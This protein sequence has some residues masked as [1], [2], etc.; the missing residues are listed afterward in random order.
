MGGVGGIGR[1]TCMVELALKAGIGELAVGL[2]RDLL[3][4]GQI[5]PFNEQEYSDVYLLP[6]TYD[7]WRDSRSFT[8]RTGDSVGDV[9]LVTVDKD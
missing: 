6:G 2:N 4:I 7:D 1:K 3:K 8:Y 9:V 5:W